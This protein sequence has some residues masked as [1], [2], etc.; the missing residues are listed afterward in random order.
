MSAAPP[1]LRARSKE[2]KRCFFRPRGAPAAGIAALL[3][4]AAA[5]AADPVDPA[6]PASSTPEAEAT[7]TAKDE[8]KAHFERGLALFDASLWDAALAEFLASIKLYTTRAAVKNAALCLRKLFRFAEALDMFERLSAMPGISDADRALADRSIEEL[9]DLVGALEIDVDQP[10]AALTIDGQARGTSPFAGPIRV[11][12]GSRLVRV[13][14]EGFEAFEARVEVAG[15]QR[16]RVRVKLTKIAEA[17]PP[18]EDKDGR[19]GG[20]GQ[21]EASKKPPASGADRAGLFVELTGAFGLAPSFG[22]DVT[23]GC[24][25][26]CSKDTGIGALVVARGAYHFEVGAEL[27]IEAGYLHER[28]DVRGRATTVRPVNLPANPGEASD[29]LTLRGAL[30]G[31]SSGLRLRGSVPLTL[32]LGA[33]ALLGSLT[34]DRSGSF[35]TIPREGKPKASYSIDVSQ[36]HFSASFYAAPEARVSVRVTKHLEL[37]LGLAALILVPLFEARWA[38]KESRVFAATDGLGSLPDESLIGDAIIVFAPGLG[39]RYDF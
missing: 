34:D 15:R 27:G 5:A 20:R 2:K 26:D 9:N 6:Q 30:I 37:S 25:G 3:I 19:F 38:P 7:D 31:A 24:S 32:R 22:G 12:V 17:A 10:S 4:S 13:V 18:G 8:A 39:V 29:A 28:Q 16:V 36:T 14:R 33:G 1:L 11:S 23:G 21:I 35:E